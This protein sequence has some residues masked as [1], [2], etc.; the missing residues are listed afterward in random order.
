MTR[1]LLD[2]PWPIG[3]V[4]DETSDGFRVL[5]QFKRLVERYKLSPVPFVEQQD[6]DDAIQRLNTHTSGR[7]TIY[8]F[9]MQCVRRIEST[10][11]AT[12][13]P[14]LNP[15]LSANWKRALRDELED[16][17]NWRS[18]QIV[19]PEKRRSVWPN[20]DEIA[21]QYEGQSG[22]ATE[23]RVLVSLGSEYYETHPFAVPDVDPWRH[24]EWLHRPSPETRD[25]GKPCRLPRPPILKGVLLE[26]LATR[27]HE[28]SQQGW[29]VGGRYFFIPPNSFQP[30]QVAKHTWRKGQAFQ[31]E[32][33]KN[34]R[35]PER[36]PGPIDY[37]G[38]IWV[39]D[40]NERHWDVQLLDGGYVRVNHEGL[41]LPKKK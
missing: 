33:T 14:V 23:Q 22:L 8:R 30:E 27:L 34:G 18:P 24:L 26:Q 35:G 36:G 29:M 1:L 31:R 3:A 15:P 16:Y 6:L 25:E 37:I 9:A 19:V 17:I 5:E 2:H 11:T 4:A 39:W 10:A 12:P 20:V 38:Q 41:L 13:I 21:I 40:N 7:G 28:A 32:M